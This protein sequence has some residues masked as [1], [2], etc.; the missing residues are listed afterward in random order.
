[1]LPRLFTFA[2]KRREG[3]KSEGVGGEEEGEGRGEEKQRCFK[4][5]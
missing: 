3:G 1:M 4:G 5:C 2:T